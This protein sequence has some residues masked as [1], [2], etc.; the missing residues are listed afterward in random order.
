MN[1]YSI[2]LNNEIIANVSGTEAAYACY[3]A[4]KT[5]AE[6]T[7]KTASLV[8]DETGE[9]VAYSDDWDEYDE[10]Y[11]PDVDECG[12]DPYEGCY[13]FDC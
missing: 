3:E 13:T 6:F 10:D 1:T 12:F 7:G 11:E 9:V 4:A 8:W 5:L 2:Y